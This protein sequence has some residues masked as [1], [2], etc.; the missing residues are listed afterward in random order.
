LA[1]SAALLVG[2]DMSVLPD[3]SFRAECERFVEK[4]AESTD[5]RAAL[6]VVEWKCPDARK[7]TKSLYLITYKDERD[8][9]TELLLFSLGTTFQAHAR[10]SARLAWSKSDP[11]VAFVQRTEEPALGGEWLPVDWSNEV[12]TIRFLGS[13]DPWPPPDSLSPP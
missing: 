5:K 4:R 9:P 6:E 10:R 7:N 1:V 12:V 8:T 2:C 3:R 13:R 11:R